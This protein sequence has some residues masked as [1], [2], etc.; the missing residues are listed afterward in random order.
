[1]LSAGELVVDHLRNVSPRSMAYS[2]QPSL[3]H[4]CAARQGC[5]CEV[6]SSLHREM[7]VAVPR[8]L[9]GVR[10]IDCSTGTAGRL[11]QTYGPGLVGENSRPS[12]T[13]GSSRPL[14]RR[15]GG[16]REPTL[17]AAQLEHARAR[18]M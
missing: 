15:H 6:Y 3:T 14:E 8:P 2:T 11:V 7:E 1:T 13:A 5:A 10:M 16:Q 12:G 17:I 9:A 18:E 4:G